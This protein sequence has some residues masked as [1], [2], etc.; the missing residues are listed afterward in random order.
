MVGFAKWD[1]PHTLT[2]EQ[3]EEKARKAREE[4]MKKVVEG[5]NGGLMREFFEQLT[6]GRE[7]WL[8]PEKTFCE[9]LSFSFCSFVFYGWI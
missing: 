6:A 9:F 4:R 3:R 5:S 2:A 7:R 1:Y 8:V